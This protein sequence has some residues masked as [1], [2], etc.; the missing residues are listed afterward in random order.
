MATTTTTAEVKVSLKLYIDKKTN[1]VVFAESGKEFIDFLFSILSLPLGT[2]TRLLSKDQTLG[3]M[4]NL[5][6][7][8]ED[9]NVMFIQPAKSKDSYLKPKLQ[10]LCTTQSNLLLLDG[11]SGT[12][13]IRR[14]MYLII[15][16][17]FL[18]FRQH[19]DCQLCFHWVFSRK[20]PCVLFPSGP[21]A[22]LRCFAY[23]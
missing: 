11:L 13:A 17:L 3:C 10:Q 15:G 16:T 19:F 1:K 21:L 7:S 4:G 18:Y 6:Q 22:V 9:L 5:F 14:L 12:P 23:F 20:I 8:V 2:V